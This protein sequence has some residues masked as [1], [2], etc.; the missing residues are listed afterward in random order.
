VQGHRF[1]LAKVEANVGGGWQAATR[2][3]YNYW[4]VGA[5]NLGAAP[6]R[7]RATDV[8]GSTIEASLALRGGDQSAA[9]QFPECR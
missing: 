4:Q 3:T 7:V 9:A 1:P 5:G 8:N 6:Y 2:Q